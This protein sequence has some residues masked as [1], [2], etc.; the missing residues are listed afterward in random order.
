MSSNNG[1]EV[2][3]ETGAQLLRMSSS[4]VSSQATNWKS[5]LLWN[6]LTGLGSYLECLSNKSEERQSLL[7]GLSPLQRSGRLARTHFRSYQ[8][9]HPVMVNKREWRW[10][11]VEGAA[12]QD[13]EALLCVCCCVCVSLLLLCVC[14]GLPQENMISGYVQ[15]LKLAAT[16]RSPVS[17]VIMQLFMLGKGE[18][19]A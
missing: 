1:P 5:W 16:R 7:T 11:G 8:V 10:R 6:A 17:E 19:S 12:R 14:S 15:L 4:L 13:D 9:S 18:Q 3:K 2:R